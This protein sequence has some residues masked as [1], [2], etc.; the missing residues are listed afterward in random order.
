[1]APPRH[2]WVWISALGLALLVGCSLVAEAVFP[3]LVYY[4]FLP[5]LVVTLVL[6]QL[7]RFKGQRVRSFYLTVRG[8]LSGMV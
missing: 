2:R 8:S 4:A 5:A 3:R 1:M 6:A 7:T